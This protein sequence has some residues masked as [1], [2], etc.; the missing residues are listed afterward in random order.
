MLVVGD[1]DV[2]SAEVSTADV[3]EGDEDDKDIAEE[4]VFEAFFGSGR[5]QNLFLQ[6]NP[7]GQQFV[8]PSSPTHSSN[9]SFIPS[10]RFVESIE[11]RYVVEFCS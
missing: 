11:F 4:V 8:L 7:D 9:L 1:V 5:T 10:N 3:D 2:V 6:V